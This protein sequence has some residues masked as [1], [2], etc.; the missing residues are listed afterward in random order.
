MPKI[1]G[2]NIFIKETCAIVALMRGFGLKYR[3]FA[4]FFLGQIGPKTI[5]WKEAAKAAA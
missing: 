5:F 2:N 4:G 3:N 1:Q